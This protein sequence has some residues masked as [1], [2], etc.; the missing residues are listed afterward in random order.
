MSYIL[1][2]LKKSH[3]ERDVGDAP[4]LT[5]PMFVDPEDV[6]FEP[7]SQA[8]GRSMWIGALILMLVATALALLAVRQGWLL[9]PG[10][11]GESVVARDAESIAA[12]ATAAAAVAG[13][14]ASAAS[15]QARAR[16]M[17]T[18]ALAQTPANAVDAAPSQPRPG[19][20]EPPAAEPIPYYLADE[21][22]DDGL[23]AAML[24]PSPS[25][26]GASGRQSTAAAYV[27]FQPRPLPPVQATPK[28]P[29]DNVL[30]LEDPDALS[31]APQVLVVPAPQ[32]GGGVARGAA[33]YRQARAGPHRSPSIGVPEP[34]DALRVPTYPDYE[35]PTPIPQDLIRDIEAFKRSVTG[36]DLSVK[37]KPRREKPKTKEEKVVSPLPTV[38][39]PLSEDPRKLKLPPE[40]AISIPP[41]VLNVHFYDPKP[42]KRFVVINGERVRE[43]K[44]RRNIKVEEILPDGAVVSYQGHRWFVAR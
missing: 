32:P 37:P 4:S 12:P 33:E 23:E 27:P 41:V 40:V 24:G 9:G 38:A 28:P 20:A 3:A 22:A 26:P 7:R 2:A 35:Q 11:S 8:G 44:K 17:D 39:T 21:I 30:P 14:K 19:T 6:D 25:L 42:A 43:G 36:S 5:T 18:A 1:E 10:E 31:V 29:A 15:D 34:A 13:S 16:S